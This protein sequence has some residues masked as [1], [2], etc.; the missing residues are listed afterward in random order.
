MNQGITDAQI[1]IIYF[2][3]TPQWGFSGTITSKG[4]KKGDSN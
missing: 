4:K 3:E 1:Y 2:I